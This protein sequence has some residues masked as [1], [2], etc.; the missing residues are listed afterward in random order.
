[1]WSI[2]NLNDE[3]LNT[4]LLSYAIKSQGI[5]Y[6]ALLDC[7]ARLNCISNATVQ[8]HKLFTYTYDTPIDIGMAIKGTPTEI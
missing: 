6:T 5:K 7:G 8:K 1:M 4:T 3:N 2:N